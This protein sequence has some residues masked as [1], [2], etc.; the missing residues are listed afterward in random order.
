MRRSSALPPAF[1]GAPTQ[2]GQAVGPTWRELPPPVA[3]VPAYAGMTERGTGTTER[4]QGR[5]RG[6]EAGN[7]E[8]P[9]TS[10]GMTELGMK[11]LV[12]GTATGA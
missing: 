4:A 3:W 7:G 12:R 11:E 8:I 5:Y 1:G 10:A 9:A 6:L 2:L